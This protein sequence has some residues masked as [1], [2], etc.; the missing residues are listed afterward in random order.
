MEHYKIST[1]SNKSTISKFVTK[2][3]IKINNLSSGKYSVK[4]NIEFN[5]SILRS[6]LWL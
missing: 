3:W 5:T 1:L 2:K 6:D 4:K